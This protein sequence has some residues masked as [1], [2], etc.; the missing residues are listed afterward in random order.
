MD[1]DPPDQVRQT[2]G[3]GAASFAP[4]V[5]ALLTM[6]VVTT[7]AVTVLLVL[8]V[9]QTEQY[10]VVRY[11]LQ[12]G[13]VLALLWYLARTGPAVNALPELSSKV[14]PRWRYGAW[15]PVVAIMLLLVLT[16][17]SDDGVDILMQLM[18]IATLWLLVVW[19]RKIRLRA[20]VQ[21]VAVALVAYLAALPAAQNGFIGETVHVLLPA[22]AAPMYVAGG[23]LIERTRLGGVQL[24][25]GSMSQAVTSVCW[26]GLLF[27]PLG[28][29]NAAEGSPG[30]GITWVT[31]WWMPLSLPWFSGIAEEVWFR[32]I[33]VGVVYFLLRPAFPNHPALV[34]LAAVLFSGITFGLGHGRTLERFLTTGLLYGVPM[35]ALFA[36]RDWEHAVGAHYMVNMIP[37]LMVYLET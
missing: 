3:E 31:E 32:L 19:W 21:G 6:W 22:V 2:T 14:L 33:L 35:A 13:Y 11:G 7:L 23:L 29:I 36:R 26:G 27:I 10:A 24:L 17:F 18:I 28:L 34:V 16:A 9:R 5:I 30:D 8:D 12:A 37:W 15:I 25:S 1:N 20:V 4:H